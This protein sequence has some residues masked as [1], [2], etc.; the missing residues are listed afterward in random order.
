MYRHYVLG[1]SLAVLLF[2]A[3]YFSRILTEP[4]PEIIPI[5]SVKNATSSGA[6]SSSNDPAKLV[7]FATFWQTWAQ[8][9]ANFYGGASSTPVAET[10]RVQAAIAGLVS[11][12]GDPYTVFLPTKQSNALKEQVRGDFEGIGAVLNM[13]DADTF[14]VTGILP[15]SPA[16]AVGLAAGDRIVSVDGAR[17][18]G[19][20]LD[21]LVSRIRGEAGTLVAIGVVHQDGTEKTFDITRGRVAL[22]TVAAQTVS[23]VRQVA[24]KVVDKADDMKNTVIDALSRVDEEADYE[25]KKENYR[26]VH[27][28]TFAESSVPAF[29]KEAEAFAASDEEVFILDL[30]DNPGGDMRV[31]AILASY[32]LPKGELITY[33]QGG[34]NLSERYESFG[35][36]TFGAKRDTACF[37][38]L[39][40]ERSA[41]ASE[42]LAAA[43]GEHKAAK[44]VGTK[45]YGKGSVQK[46]IDI[47]DIGSL[48]VTIAHWY[49]PSGTSLSHNG[50]TPEIPV[51]QELNEPTPDPFVNTAIQSCTKE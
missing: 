36:D 25:A 45:T 6:L 42:I 34:N 15:H 37:A 38:V 7:D 9:D 51:N 39:V 40:N 1:V 10:E 5:F 11:A 18:Q 3:G 4:D 33:A 50:Y 8:L 20:T 35:I 12:Y 23:Q 24:K 49:T 21:G 44:I 26:I 43:L 46:L 2:T 30:R 32:Y 14:F 13:F 48:K 29:N 22:P 17:V 31:A 28:S 27:L 16:E 41:S 19:T 47:A